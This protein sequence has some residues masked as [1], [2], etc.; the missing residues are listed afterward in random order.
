MTPL[1]KIRARHAIYTKNQFE[2]KAWS[3]QKFLAGIDEVGR[4]CLAGP[5]VAA[6]AILPLNARHRLIKDSKILTAPQREQA[7]EWLAQHAW[8]GIGIVHNRIV[9]QHNIWQATILAM[10][11]ALINA[12]LQCPHTIDTLLVDAMPL[13]LDD[14]GLSTLPIHYFPK[15]ETISL[16][17]AAASIVAKVTRDRIMQRMDYLFPQYHLAEHKGY[18]TAKHRRALE[19]QGAST[20]HRLTF[21][22]ECSSVVEAEVHEEQQSLC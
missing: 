9:D 5:L 22:H 13:R 15:G 2:K 11:R 4:G 17:I 10:K 20:I 1:V 21:L 3:E 6:A 14:M 19:Q 12:T 8:F 7:Y 16:S 18:A